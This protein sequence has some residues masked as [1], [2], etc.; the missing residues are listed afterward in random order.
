MTVPIESGETKPLLPE[1]TPT[2]MYLRLSPDG[3]KLAY[4]AI[5][6]DEKAVSLDAKLVIHEFDGQNVGKTEKEMPMPFG[7]S[8]EWSSDGKSMIST[9]REGNSNIMSYSLDGGKPKKLTEFN[10]GK[11]I[12]LAWSADRKKLYVV[13]GIFNSDLILI[14]ETQK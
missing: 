12:T 5:S 10:S 6:Y 8:F 13:R 4:C 11:I 1:N 3:R 7:D 2:Q 14:R 9:P